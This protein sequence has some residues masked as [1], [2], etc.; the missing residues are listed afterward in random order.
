MSFN[1]RVEM[2]MAETFYALRSCL[3]ALYDSWWRLLERWM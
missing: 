1:H 3:Q 2:D